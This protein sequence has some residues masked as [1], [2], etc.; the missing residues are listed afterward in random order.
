M[1]IGK[2]IRHLRKSNGMKQEFLAEKLNISINAI[3]QYETGKRNVD[4]TTMKKL[5]EIF[6]VPIDYFIDENFKLD[7][8][9]IENKDQKSDSQQSLNY[10]IA[11]LK[12]LIDQGSITSLD[13]IKDEHL[14]ALITMLKKDADILLK[15]KGSN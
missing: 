8:S 9:S 3:S 2:K 4:L 11:L 12:G 7:D 10:T 13:D 15:E 14:E 5:A 6:D 1:D